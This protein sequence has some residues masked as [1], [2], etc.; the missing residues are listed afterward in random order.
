MNRFDL[1]ESMNAI[2]DDIL[3]RSERRRIPRWRSAVAAVLVLALLSGALLWVLPLQSDTPVQPSRPSILPT[4]SAL[5]EAEYPTMAAFPDLS[6][7]FNQGEFNWD[8]YDKDYAAWQASVE[9]Q[10]RPDGYAGNLTPFFQSSIR[11]F[12]SDAGTEN[13]AYSPLNVYMALAMLAELSDSNS[14]QQ[15]LDLVGADSIE[16]LRSQANDVWNAQYRDDGA[17]TSILASSLWLSDTVTYVPETMQ[18][19]SRTYYASA[20]QGRMGSEELDN[21]L[22]SWLS[23]QT[24]GLLDQQIQDISLDADTVLALATTLYFQAKW[25]QEFHEQLN[26][27]GTFYAP[28]GEITCE[29]MCDSSEGTYYWGGQFGAV[30]RKLENN[31]G[32]MWFLLPDEGVSIDSLLADSEALDFLLANGSWENQK[33]VTVHLSLPKFDVTSQMDLKSGLQA[34]GVTDVFDGGVSDFSPMTDLQGISLTSAQHDVRVAID[35]QGVTAAAYTV[36][37]T[38]G[39]GGPPEDEVY[40]ELNRPFVFVITSADGLPLFAGLVQQPGQ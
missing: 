22:R 17:T 8:A 27:S 1:Y 12:L 4:V 40:F 25:R 37:P 16:T 36:M 19:L 3:Q 28:T 30:G 31:S 7:Y 29:Y 11:Q 26:T 34:L 6:N 35:E 21:A 39:A 15:I 18:Q 2:D 14:R 10:Q 32:T 5:S 24:G 33:D 38:E 9:N 23:S 20:Y 13:R